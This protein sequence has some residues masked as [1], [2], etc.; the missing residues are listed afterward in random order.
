MNF[1]LS[2]EQEQI[3]RSV[4]DFAES[5]MR[6]NVHEWDEA[7]KFPQD[8]LRRKMGELGWLGV[9]YP[10]EYG[11]AG[12]GYAEYA[13]IM[14]ELAR[15][16]PAVALSVAA[17]NSLCSGHIYVAG[18]EEQKREYLPKLTSGEV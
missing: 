10:E 5:E 3:R 13:I 15:V 4:R 2:D 14:E 11:G 7:Q 18:S 12:M 1:E 16:D 8:D 6:P 9:I 17:H